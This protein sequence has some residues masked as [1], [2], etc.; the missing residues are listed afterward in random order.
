M[1]KCFEIVSNWY[2]GSRE[3]FPEE[4]RRAEIIC[5]KL[6]CGLE[7]MSLAAFHGI[8]GDPTWFTREYQAT[9]SKGN[10]RHTKESSSSHPE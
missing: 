4:V 1:D 3:L 6:K 5:E 2:N 10:S 8:A 7:M 9:L